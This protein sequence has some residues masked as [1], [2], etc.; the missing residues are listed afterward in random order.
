MGTLS[1]SA[2]TN[3]VPVLWA[4]Q[5]ALS[6]MLK[7]SKG[8]QRKAPGGSEGPGCHPL[9]QPHHPLALWLGCHTE[10]SYLRLLQ[11][12]L[13]QH[14]PH[15]LHTLI[16]LPILARHPGLLKPLLQLRTF[17]KLAVR[18]IPRSSPTKAHG[19]E[20]HSPYSLS[21]LPLGRKMFPLQLTA[22]ENPRAK[23]C[24]R[25]LSHS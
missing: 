3:C 16:F 10:P 2:G 15:N 19:R 8:F 12:I 25:L 22:P 5:D 9:P 6:R 7:T 17:G 13:F 20:L 18:T 4:A 21:S 24:I 23:T 11:R 1:F 14:H